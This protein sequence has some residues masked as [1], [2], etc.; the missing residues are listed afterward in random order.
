MLIAVAER[1][2]RRLL[3]AAFQIRR[4]RYP[5]WARQWQFWTVLGVAAILRLFAIGRSPFGSD[6]AL[7]FLEASRAVHDHLLPGTGIYNSVLALNMPL[8]TF[9]LLPFATNPQALSVV[10]ALANV[11]AV[12]GWYV[13]VQRYFG[14]R[15]ALIA[16]LLFATACYDTY[17][18]EFVWQQT[19]LAPLTVVVF[20]SA[21]WGALERG[22]HWLVPHVLALAALIQIYPIMAALLP[23]TLI[24]LWFGRRAVSWLDVA[25]ASVGTIALYLPALL[26]EL[27]SHGYDLPIYAAYLRAPKHTD[28]QVFEA[29]AQAL[30]PRPADF[31]GAGTPYALAADRFSWLTPALMLLWLA[32]TLWL[33][34]ALA[35]PLIA[36]MPRGRPLR[37]PRLAPL[38]QRISRP[39]WLGAA[40]L[41]VWPLALVAIT[42]RHSSAVYVHYVFEITPVIYCTI[43][44]FLTR[45]PAQ[46]GALLGRLSAAASPGRGG[47]PW[48]RLL[49]GT[50]RGVPAW[51]ALSLALLIIVAQT[52]L[53]SMLVF[54]LGSGQAPA[55]S[56]GATPTL[57]YMRV[58]DAATAW[59][60]RLH[61]QDVFVVADPGDPYMGLYWAQRANDLASDHGTVWSSNVETDCALAPS[62]QM[63]PAVVVAITTAQGALQWQ[64]AS[65]G[66]RVLQG[67]SPARGE[68]FTVYRAD[69]PA[70]PE[71]TRSLASVGGELR[72]DSVAL[73]AAS[74]ST[75]ARLVS[76]WT[77]LRTTPPG[78]AVRQYFFYETVSTTHAAPVQLTAACTPSAWIAGERVE[79]VSVLPAGVSTTGGVTAQIQVAGGTHSW[80]QPSA[81]SLVLET[82]K[83]LITEP[84][85]LPVSGTPPSASSGA[86]PVQLGASTITV[87]LPAPT[88]TGA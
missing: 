42:L 15:A 50:L 36:Q 27:G 38:S 4:H 12:G 58:M 37:A 84:V 88:S 59:A 33:L 23:L 47:W 25:L 80:Y 19:I 8:Y 22:R 9:I 16:G 85:T 3:A 87:S 83:E 72:L 43:A 2:P 78:P 41:L 20:A 51:L 46:L 32:S 69:P 48:P 1:V 30:G 6:D 71:N 56:W 65:G 5:A 44:L 75:P 28:T 39:D 54:T 77:V 45:F 26:F 14:R 73:L 68:V 53:T 63:G 31:F 17:M 76:D 82:A 49:S 24:A 13:F 57:G 55:A 74:G 81:G 70:A 62:R 35:A 7:L 79:V 34:C 10:T 21:Y 11:A 61:S 18:S 60:Q 29:L 66:L 40:M 86:P 67:Y 52:I 64:L